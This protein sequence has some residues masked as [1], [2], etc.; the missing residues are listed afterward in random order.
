MNYRNILLIF[1]FFFIYGCESP[2]NTK[3]EKLNFEIEN[4]YK[5]AGFALIY[6]D[7]LDGIKKIEERSLNIYHKTLK[8]NSMVKITNLNNGISLIAKVKSNKVKFSDFYNSVLSL[9]I[10]EVLELDKNEPYIEIILISKDSTFIA[11]KAKTF[12]EESVV[13]EKA[14]VDGIQISDLNEKKIKKKIIKDKN[15]LYSIKVA[16]FYYKDS[17]K[18][19]L[20]KIKSESLVKNLKIIE[21]S[22]TKYRL[23]IGPFNDIK[24]LKETFE[25]MSLFNFENLEILKN[26]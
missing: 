5:N 17:A 2:I 18:M 24:S 19:M 8:K 9:R 6:N 11:K 4:K 13:A 1:L 16:D 10:A 20:E 7:E 25:N 15:F 22:K 12:E 23:L 21:M 3:K 14:P 26:A